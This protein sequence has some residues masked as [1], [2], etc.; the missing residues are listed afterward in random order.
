MQTVYMVFHVTI[1]IVLVMF[2]HGD[3]MNC[4]GQNR[5]NAAVFFGDSRVDTGNIYRETGDTWPAPPYY[6]GR[7]CNGPNWV[8]YLNVPNKT[9]YAYAGA[10]SDSNLAQG[11]VGPENIP[12]PGVH[13]Q[14]SMYFNNTNNAT[15]NFQCTLYVI[16]VGADNYLYNPALAQNPTIVADSLRDQVAELIVMGAKHIL[17]FNEEPLYLVP[18]V[19]ALNF[20]T[21][22]Y[23]VI[24]QQ[25]SNLSSLISALQSNYNDVSIQIFDVYS[26]ILSIINGN[27][28]SNIVDPCW[29]VP[30]FTVVSQCADP[31]SYL[32]VDDFH[33]TTVVHQLIANNVSQFFSSGSP[34]FVPYS[35]LARFVPIIVSQFVLCLIKS[36]L[37]HSQFVPN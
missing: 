12:P 37:I 15:I 24:I 6:H 7:F 8:D 29:N 28:L 21:I 27:L 26:L 17:I 33:F 2:S 5:F 10:T 34:R 14:I 19:R 16:W 3:G 22:L 30:N 23:S 35:F 36:S 32:F 25:N 11:Y 20:A 31:N 4:Q 18:E 9:N 13:Q 1:I